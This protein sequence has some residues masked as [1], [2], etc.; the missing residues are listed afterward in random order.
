MRTVER[1]AAGF[2]CEPGLNM[3]CWRDGA[4]QRVK[5]WTEL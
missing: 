4:A 1:I 5:L 3:M 2:L